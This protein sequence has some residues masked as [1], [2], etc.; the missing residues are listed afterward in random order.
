MYE[1]AKRGLVGY[2][3]LLNAL[4]LLRLFFC[5]GALNVL[6]LFLMA[7]LLLR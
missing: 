5:F 6:P 7:L 4:Q 2:A 3:I 1:E